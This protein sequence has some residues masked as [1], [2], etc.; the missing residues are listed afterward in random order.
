MTHLH[1]DS[2]TYYLDQLCLIALSA[3][4]GA[5]CLTLYFLNTK[6]LQLMLGAQFHDFV[7]ISGFVLLGLAVLRAVIL[8]RQVA[9][10]KAAAAHAH[11]HDHAHADCC[12]HEHEHGIMHREEH[13]HSHGGIVHSHPPAPLDVHGHAHDHGHS[14]EHGPEHTHA[15]ADHDH[16]WAPWRYVVLLLPVFLF[17]LG[18]PNRPPRARATNVDINPTEMITAYSGLVAEAYDPLTGLLTMVSLYQSGPT[19]T[20]KVVPFKDLQEAAFKRPNLEGT[21]VRVK[22]QFAPSR[23]NERNFSLAR[24]RMQCCASD[25]VQLNIPVA[26]RESVSPLAIKP[27]EW[28]EVTG[29]VE[30][31][32]AERGSKMT[33]LRVPSTRLIR[34]SDPDPDPWVN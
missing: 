33:I 5:V 32:G 6:M 27:G 25:A 17:M 16:G 8:W 7:G 23:R 2:D 24:F 3:A 10:L 26:C 22:G 21:W 13:V 31:L 4:F 11:S 20:P 19:E 9:K 12:G 28:V 1:E 30:F 18:L 14:H 15:H 34:L 29:R